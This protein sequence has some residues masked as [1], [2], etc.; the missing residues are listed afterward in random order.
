MRGHELLQ[1]VLTEEAIHEFL[2]TRELEDEVL[3][4]GEYSRTI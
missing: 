4:S 1:V 2:K 3:S